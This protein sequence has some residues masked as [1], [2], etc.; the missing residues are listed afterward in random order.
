MSQTPA[1]TFQRLGDSW[2]LLG[3]DGGQHHSNYRASFCLTLVNTDICFKASSG[4]DL[5]IMIFII[6]GPHSM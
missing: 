3:S 4:E 2:G 1:G 5:D 6:M